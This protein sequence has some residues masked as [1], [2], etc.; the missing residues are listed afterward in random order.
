MLCR[1]K[2]TQKMLGKG[3]FRPFSSLKLR[4]S[5]LLP[6]VQARLSKLRKEKGELTLATITSDQVLGGMRGIQA[7]LALT[8][9]LDGNSGILFR[10]LTIQDCRAKLPKKLIEPLPEGMIYL[11]M[12]GEVPNAEQAEEVRKEVASRAVVPETVERLVRSLPRSMHPMTQLSIGVLALQSGSEFLRGYQ[13]GLAKVDYWKPTYEDALN[14]IARIPRIAAIIYRQTYKDG[15]IV[16]SDPHLD[17]AANFAQMLG[18]PEASFSELMRLYMILHC[19]L[20]NS[21]ASAHTTHMVG[22]ALSDAYLAYS[23]GLNALAGPLHGLAN[24]EC[25]KFLLNLQASVGDDPTS[26]AVETYVK[27]LLQSGQLVPGYGHSVLRVTDPRFTCEM[28]FAARVMPADPL[29]RLVRICSEVVPRVLAATGKVKNPWPNVDAQSGALLYHY[30][31]REFDFYTVLFGVS[32][33]IGTMCSLVWS[34]GLGLPIERPESVTL[35]WLSAFAK[36]KAGSNQ[37]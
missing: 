36:G 4:F 24:Q 31:L 8:S 12:T 37:P 29:C 18:Y 5:Q 13:V 1:S 28:D 6:D 17:L 3:L 14:L 23:A 32:R 15:S 30:G 26:E 34:R 20:E 10:G 9:K 27:G 2:S 7:T 33:A 35:E 11:L 22:S 25:L 19:D 21:N 16:P